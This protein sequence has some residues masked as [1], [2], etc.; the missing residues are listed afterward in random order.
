MID[1]IIDYEE[2]FILYGEMMKVMLVIVLIKLIVMGY[3]ELDDYFFFDFI[4]N[5]IFIRD[6]VVMINDYIFI[7]KVVKEVCYCE[8]F[9]ICFIIWVYFIFQGLCEVNKV[10]NFNK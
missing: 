9:I 5:F 2:L 3:Y 7:I 1:L 8:N 6:I 4:L 10:I